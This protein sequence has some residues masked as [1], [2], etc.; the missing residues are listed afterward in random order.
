[1]PDPQHTIHFF[2]RLHG[3]AVRFSYPLTKEECDRFCENFKME[4]AILDE[5][6][7]ISFLTAEQRSIH[8]GTAHLI[9][10][11]WDHETP[12]THPRPEDDFVLYVDGLIEPFRIKTL[13]STFVNN[14]ESI[15]PSSRLDS[16]ADF[17]SG[18]ATF[19]FPVRNI[20][21][22]DCIARTESIGE[23]S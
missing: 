1:M 22:L 23:T 14:M 11:K 7:F 19:V 20:V 10:Y 6:P 3:E 4:D 16:V 9:Y 8:I 12:P 2:L 5:H 21:L 18:S 13:D 15:L 17:I